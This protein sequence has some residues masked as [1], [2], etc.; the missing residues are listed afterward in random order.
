MS[1]L[2]FERMTSNLD[3]EN[4]MSNPV[5]T[6]SS[7]QFDCTRKT[8]A[9]RRRDGSYTAAATIAKWK[10]NNAVLGGVNVDDKPIR[11]A[12]AKGSKKGCMK[13]KG[14]PDNSRCNYRGVRQR[15]WGKWVAEIRAPKRGSRLW[16][17][18]FPTALDAAMAYD[19]AARAMYGSSARLNLPNYVRHTSVLKADSKDSGDERSEVCDGESM[20]VTDSEKKSKVEVPEIR[21]GEIDINDYLENYTESEKKS[22]AEACQI[23]SGD[24]D[25]NDYL[26]NYTPD[27][28]FDVNELLGAIDA[29][30]VCDTDY[31]GQFGCDVSGSQDAGN[32]DYAGFISKVEN[33]HIQLETPE[34]LKPIPELQW[35]SSNKLPSQEINQD[36]KMFNCL[37]LLADFQYGTDYDLDSFNPGRPEDWNALAVDENAFLD[38]ADLGL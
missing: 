15:T 23:E 13:G 30:P 12:P 7:L 28:M 26:Q 29:G 9:R 31:R 36:V 14:G 6:S 38:L 37:D 22:Q 24:I 21:S 35:P 4:G 8:K 16:L 10:E 17:G 19:E 33:D 32:L 11:K 1:N 3:F 5:S 18:T 25:I 34:N 20:V 27:E 2:I